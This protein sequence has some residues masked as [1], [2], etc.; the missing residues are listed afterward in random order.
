M[1]ARHVGIRLPV[2]NALPHKELFVTACLDC[3]VVSVKF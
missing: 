1:R 3:Q 2:A